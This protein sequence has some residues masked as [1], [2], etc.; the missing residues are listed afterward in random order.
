MIAERLTVDDDERSA[1]ILKRFAEVFDRPATHLIEAPGRVNL[2]GEHTDYNGL[3]V[4][5]MAVDRSVLVAAAPA[6]DHIVRLRNLD[7]AAY[8]ARSYELSAELPPYTGG[9][10]GNYH[11]AAANGVRHTRYG[12]LR[13]GGDFLVDGNIP[14]GAGLSSSSALVVA[15]ALGLLAVNE[16]EV[17]YL[18]LAELLPSAER[19][20][21]TLSG[22]M[23]QAVSLLA[24]AQ[25]ALRI[26]FFPLRVQPVP[27]PPGHRIVVCHSL[28]TAEKSGRARHAY[29]L[30]VVECRLAA[31]V[32]EVSLAPAL[33]RALTRLGDLAQLFPA[34]SLAEFLPGLEAHVPAR[35]LSLA[36]VARVVGASPAQLRLDCQIPADVGDQFSLFRRARHVLTEAD[37]VDRAVPLLHA[38]D[39]A[40]FGALMDA[41]H[42]S[43]RDDYDISC[44]EVEELVATA[45]ESGA[46]GAR[47]TGAGFGGCIVALVEADVVAGFL[48]LLDRRFYRPRL[49]SHTSAASHRFVFQPCAGASVKPVGGAERT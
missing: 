5:P 40:G 36:E 38:G 31:R 3:P 42:A 10:W 43:C 18:E 19:Y 47:V 34:R 28:V 20:V 12:D 2:L 35:P 32:C 24:Q 23:D 11:K 14:A 39:A 44:P 33:P 22:G 48:E 6:A 17:P 46:L 4:L 49:G 41:S 26:D 37:R 21:G 15:S 30:R 7:D 45:K 27:L 16:I 9:D 1:A 29:N 8:P 13:R 25:R